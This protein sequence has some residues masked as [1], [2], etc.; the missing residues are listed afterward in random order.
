MKIEIKLENTES[1]I[2]FQSFACKIYP[3][4]IKWHTN[5]SLSI[6]HRIEI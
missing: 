6:F 3:D 4:K 2:E 5:I 1:L